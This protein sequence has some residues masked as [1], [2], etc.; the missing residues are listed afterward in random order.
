[1]I[2]RM[3]Q[4]AW[5]ATLLAVL[6]IGFSASA[7]GVPWLVF[8]DADSDTVCD[9]VNAANT[10]LVVLAETGELVRVAGTDIIFADTFVDDNGFVFFQGQPAGF[11][12]FAVDADGFR[13][14]W[15]F[16]AS[17]DLANVNEFTGEPGSTGALPSEFV[18][19]PCD[20]CA[21]W[22]DPDTCLD[23]DHDGV[24][25]PDDDCANTPIDEEADAGGCSCSQLD[26]DDDGVDDC[27]DLCPE[28]PPIL[29]VDDD[30]CACEEVDDDRDGVN[31]C[32]DFC[33]GTPRGEPVD[34]LG[35]SC[36]QVDSDDDGLGDCDDLCPGTISGQNVDTDGC[37]CRQRDDDGD[38]VDN[39]DDLC[40]S[41][42]ADDEVDADGCTVAAPPAPSVTL[43]FCGGLG[44]IILPLMFL[45]LMTM[46]RGFRVKN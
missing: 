22:D 42:P 46:R 34:G 39:C 26:T 40:P 1:M 2:Q 28:T 35:C 7:Q 16:F 17:N 21:L 4:P 5:P 43:N 24:F 30:G 41:T 13:T 37:S 12:D 45:S 6:S 19:V 33:L 3:N 23:D 10:E 27:V 32:E 11:I 44:A 25:N 20:A 15:W 9:V 29:D 14:L 8:A 36:S 31:E 18:D 38:S